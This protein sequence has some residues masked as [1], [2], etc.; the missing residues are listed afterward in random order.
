M[1]KPIYLDTGAFVKLYVLEPGSE[2]VQKAV[3]SLRRLSFNSLQEAELRNA[4]RAAVGRGLI[5]PKAGAQ[6]ISNVEEDLRVGRLVTRPHSWEDIWRRAMALGSM[7]TQT[8][9]CRTLDIVHVALAE[10][11]KAKT[12]I[13]GD[14]R[15]AELCRRLKM[16]V[17][18]V[19]PL[20]PAPR[21]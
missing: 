5:K 18:F 10:Q 16:N 17:I 13:T 12:M 7:H 2:Q 4:I 6:A 8:L 14:K 11:E 1:V 3:Q 9:L 21:H 20:D 15:Q 19:S